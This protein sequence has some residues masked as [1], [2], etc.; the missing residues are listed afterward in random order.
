M[1]RFLKKLFSRFSFVAL[2]I[3]LIFIVDVLLVAAIVLF[4]YGLC[5]H[6]FPV[7]EPYMVWGLRVLNWIIMFLAVLQIGRAH[8]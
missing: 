5:V 1:K 6:V 4:L 2:T 8:V 3:I 7:S